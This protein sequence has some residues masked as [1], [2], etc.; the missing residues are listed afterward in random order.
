MSNIDPLLEKKILGIIK[1]TEDSLTVPELADY[2]KASEEDVLVAV[3]ELVK[4]NKIKW[5][6]PS[7]Q[8]SKA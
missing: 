8:E 2:T 3:N 6:E 5:N 4:A 7:D 1:A